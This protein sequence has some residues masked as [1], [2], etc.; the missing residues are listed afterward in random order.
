MNSPA[1]FHGMKK[2][3]KRSEFGGTSDI[4]CIFSCT[5]GALFFG[6][7]FGRGNFN[8][9]KITAKLRKIA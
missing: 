6:A 4:F 8:S 3:H 9:C 7:L 5:F 2:V 1:G